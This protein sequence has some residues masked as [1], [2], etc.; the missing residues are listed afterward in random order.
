MTHFTLFPTTG[1]CKSLGPIGIA[2]W[3]KWPYIIRALELESSLCKIEL[4]S[5]LSLLQLSYLLLHKAEIAQRIILLYNKKETTPVRP[6]YVPKY[7][8]I[9]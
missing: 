7:K 5:T 6:L 2:D 4:Y 8:S 9:Y 1:G 3:L